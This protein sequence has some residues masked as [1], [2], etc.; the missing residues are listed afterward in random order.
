MVAPAPPL[1][2]TE[3]SRRFTTGKPGKFE[4]TYL[5][6][7]LVFGPRMFILTLGNYCGPD[8]PWWVVALI[9]LT[10]CAVDLYRRRDKDNAQ[11]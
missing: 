4:I 10:W 7:F 5:F 6:Y 11:T 8:Q 3:M 9:A 1:M 2:T